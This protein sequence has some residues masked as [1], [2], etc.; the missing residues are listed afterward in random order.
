MMVVFGK[1]ASGMENS[2]LGTATRLVDELSVSS[3]GPSSPVGKY[4]GV[5]FALWKISLCFFM[6]E[7]QL[8]VPQ[9]YCCG[10]GTREANL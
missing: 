7:E 4:R 1:A 10:Y 3:I 6:G 8:K 2:D 5:L 9:G